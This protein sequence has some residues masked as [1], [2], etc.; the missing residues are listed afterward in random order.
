[1]LLTASATAFLKLSASISSPSAYPSYV[2]V[3]LLLIIKV[4]FTPLSPTKAVISEER[5]SNT[6]T[7]FERIRETPFSII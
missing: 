4:L 6:A 7:Q 2:Q 3:Y 1:M 5:I